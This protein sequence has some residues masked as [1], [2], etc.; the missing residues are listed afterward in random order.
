MTEDRPL[1]PASWELVEPLGTERLVI[2]SFTAADVDAV[3]AS[4]SR[5]DVC[6]YLLYEPRDRD[7]VAAKLDEYAPRRRIEQQGDFVQL[8]VERR[9]DGAVLGELYFTVTSAMHRGGEIGWVF[10]PDHGGRGYAT[11]AA[12]A[13]LAVAFDELRLHRVI[14]NVDP[15]NGASARRVRDR[16]LSHL[17]VVPNCRFARVIPTKRHDA[18]WGTPHSGARRTG[19]RRTRGARR[20]HPTRRG[21]PSR[22]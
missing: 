22:R 21:R 19:A 17:R 13:M 12:R 3:H 9:E 8:A 20:D 10:H 2:R 4:Q 1:L 18:P 11:E 6:R 16:R 7:A 15:R 14:A 5:D